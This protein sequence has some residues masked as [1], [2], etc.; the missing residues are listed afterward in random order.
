MDSLTTYFKGTSDVMITGLKFYLC[1]RAI[2]L[3]S[4]L[5][6]IRISVVKFQLWK[7]LNIA[8]I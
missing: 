1:A 4:R 8:N 5:I 2:A 7:K 6:V 3:E